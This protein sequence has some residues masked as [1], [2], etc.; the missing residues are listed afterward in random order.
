MFGF[1]KT[2]YTIHTVHN[3]Y[4]TQYNIYINI[5]D[6]TLLTYLIIDSSVIKLECISYKSSFLCVPYCKHI[7]RQHFDFRF[8]GLL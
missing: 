3:T 6:N 4:C 7:R 1:H 2:E 8:K 5:I